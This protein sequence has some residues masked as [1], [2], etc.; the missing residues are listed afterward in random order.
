M[1]NWMKN[2]SADMTTDAPAAIP[3]EVAIIGAGDEPVIVSPCV[4]VAVRAHS[5]VPPHHVPSRILEVLVVDGPAPVRRRL[6]G[7]YLHERPP[8]DFRGNLYAREL[9]QGRRVV[10]VLHQRR[11]R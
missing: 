1:V 11:G 4:G 7:G 3:E 5:V 8:L 6:A 9:E 2:A 10:D